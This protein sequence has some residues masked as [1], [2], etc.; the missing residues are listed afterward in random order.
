MKS[1]SFSLRSCVGLLPLVLGFVM[2]GV[3]GL[4]QAA[5]AD[6]PIGTLEQVATFN[7]AMPTGVT[8]SRTNR[9]FVNFPRWGD[10][11]PFTVAE[12]V[13]GQAVAYPDEETNDWPGRKV[14]DPTTYAD[15]EQNE[16]HFVSVQSVVV[17]P[18]NRLWVLDTG[19]PMLKNALPGGPE[20]GGD[21]LEDEQGGEANPAA[22]SGGGTDELHERC[23]IRSADWARCGCGRDSRHRVHHGLFGEGADGIRGS[24]PGNGRGL[25]G[26]G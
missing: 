16:A 2:S 14:S 3:P 10:D 11:V 25:A 22:A 17:D 6:Q 15:R 18:A 8:V 1:Q 23:S 4:G 9:I 13:N 24:G 12:V 21:R 5:V 26:I 20:A 7:G 19:S